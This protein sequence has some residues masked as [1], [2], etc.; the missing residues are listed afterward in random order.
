MKATTTI[1]TLLTLVALSAGLP[2][3][4]GGGDVTDS[5]TLQNP[6]SMQKQRS[7]NLEHADER[8]DSQDILKRADDVLT[9]MERDAELQQAL[10]QAKGVFLMPDFGRGALVVGGRGGQGVVFAKVGE[11][12]HGPAFYNMGAI[13]VGAQGGATA[14]RVAML[15]M[16][17]EAVDAF[18][19]N[20]N[21]ALNADAGLTLVDWSRQAQGSWGQGDVILWS[22]TKG[23]F[24]GGALSVSD[25]FADQEANE[26][27]YSGSGDVNVMRILQGDVESDQ[28]ADLI[29]RL[30]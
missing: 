25:V 17:D 21:F 23:V 20:H 24:A 7:T 22:D 2:A 15:L 14:G 6:Q 16:T 13:S 27:F 10:R 19:Q 12:W 3:Q 18:K 4:Q 26:E 1:F 9:A 29:E 5:E 30:P 11:Q 8:R 28:P